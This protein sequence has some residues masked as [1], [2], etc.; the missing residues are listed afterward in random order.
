MNDIQKAAVKRLEK[1]LGASGYTLDAGQAPGPMAGIWLYSCNVSG[2]KIKQ[3]ASFQLT[4]DTYREVLNRNEHLFSALNED[5][6]NLL[7]ALYFQYDRNAGSVSA[8]EK[9]VLSFL[10]IKFALSSDLNHGHEI[11]AGMHFIILDITNNGGFGLCG[12]AV[13]DHPGILTNDEVVESVEFFIEQVN[14]V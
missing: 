4:F 12:F 9:Q 2:Q 1:K 3:R 7:H 8:E 14:L 6:Q 5:E 10:L 11:S 13:A